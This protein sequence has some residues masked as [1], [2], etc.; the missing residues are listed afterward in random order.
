VEIRRDPCGVIRHPCLDTGPG[1]KAAQVQ[2]YLF[3]I[4]KPSPDPKPILPPNDC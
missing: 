3:D 2:R 1:Q 4:A